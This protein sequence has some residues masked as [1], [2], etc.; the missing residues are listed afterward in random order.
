MSVTT[1][2][3]R[4]A[5][6][7][8]LGVSLIFVAVLLRGQWSALATVMESARSFDWSFHP[9]WIA[10][11]IAL[12]IGNLFLMALV[13]TDLFRRTGGTAGHAEAIRVWVVT[14]FGRYIPGKVWQLGGLAV[15]MKGRGDSGAAA[16]VSAVAFQIIA[17]VTGAAIAVASI[18]VGWAG[19]EGGW[20]PGLM[21]L[22][23]ILLVG[24]HPGV[25]SRIARRLGSWFGETEVSVALSATDV[26]RAAAGMLV[27][28]L[29]Y[30]SGL[31]DARPGGGRAI[32]TG[33]VACTYGCLRCQLHRRLPCTRG[34]GWTGRQGRRH[35]R[36]AGGD[37][38]T[39]RGSCRPGG[40]HR[41][42]V[43][44]G[45]GARCPRRRTGMEGSS[46]KQQERVV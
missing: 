2:G 5:T 22:A 11:A 20:L 1:R 33:S 15:Y 17:L 29:L 30:W 40:H 13:W 38:R 4:I 18:G 21:T 6:L 28:W 23:L 9:W 12:G 37:R 24:L 44:G 31:S 8:F 19:L 39:G 16:L 25:L 42:V 10:G 36:A 3:R 32:G 34:S 41:T 46:R 26:A 14:N 7:A 27:A 43:D 35:D 45:Y